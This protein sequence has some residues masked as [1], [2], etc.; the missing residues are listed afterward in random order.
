MIYYDFYESN[1]SPV[2][3]IKNIFSNKLATDGTI[4]GKSDLLPFY[5]D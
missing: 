2:N 5:I 4:K 1:I 3:S